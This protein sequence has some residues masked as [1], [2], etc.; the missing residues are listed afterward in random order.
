MHAMT[1]HKALIFMDKKWLLQQNTNATV[2][3]TVID[4]K[5]T[6]LTKLEQWSKNNTIISKKFDKVRIPP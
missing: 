2:P 1:E 4:K 6:D 3:Q 5:Q